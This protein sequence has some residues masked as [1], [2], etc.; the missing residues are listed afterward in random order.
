MG[1]SEEFCRSGV[2]TD[3]RVL[4]NMD[5]L[6]R[7]LP[8]FA[9]LVYVSCWLKHYYPAAFCA[10]LINSQTDGVFMLQLSWLQMLA[11]MM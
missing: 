6:N 5:F 9:L 11:S 1:L 4:V 7:T 10:S 3:S 8:V 2:P